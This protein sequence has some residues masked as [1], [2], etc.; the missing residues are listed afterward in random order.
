[1]PERGGEGRAGASMCATQGHLWGPA[2][3]CTMCGMIQVSG[4]HWDLW[5]FGAQPAQ[6]V[7][8]QGWSVVP[9][10][11]ICPP[12]ANKECERLDC[13]RKAYIPTG[14]GGAVR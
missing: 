7:L 3:T 14:C 6:P 2:G 13:P 4:G 10:G 11:C 1:M 5:P 9:I 8:P 12:G